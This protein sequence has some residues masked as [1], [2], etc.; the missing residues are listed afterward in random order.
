MRVG[1]LLLPTDPWPE[2]V[3]RVQQL[4][5]LGYDHL[6]T[7][8]HLTWRRYRERPWHAAI[9]WLTGVACATSRVEIGTLVASPN[10]RHPVT[11][12]QEAV[13]LDH[14]SGG[15]LVLGVGTG[16]VGFDSTVF[17]GEPLDPKALSARLHEFVEV[18][19]G[20]FRE[21]TISY[22]GEYYTVNEASVRAASVREPRVPLAIAAGGRRNLGLVARYGDAWITYG[23]TTR[24]ELTPAGTVTVVREQSRRLDEACVAIERDPSE[25]RRIYL[26][27]NTAARP[28]DSV[29]AFQDFVGQ[30]AELG[31]TDLVFHHPR[32]DD[33]VW[34]E[35]ESIVEEI[36]TEVLPR[37]RPTQEAP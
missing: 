20:L 34:N 6:W 24:R 32:S 5:A 2:T 16:G 1:V 23:D 36:A 22:A 33:P 11:L 9:P 10:I 13:T 7:Y 35:P 31:F 28:L 8:D 4:E 30:Y 18:I 14:V 12:A 37:W 19:D 25:I 29:G 17:G 15:R 3:A 21:P 26:I 27:G